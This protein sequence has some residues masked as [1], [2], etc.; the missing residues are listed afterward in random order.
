VTSDYRYI[1]SPGVLESRFNS[2]GTGF[3]IT[4]DQPTDRAGANAAQVDCGTV[5]EV[6]LYCILYMYQ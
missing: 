4:F 2:A 1:S 6:T 5:I 3:A